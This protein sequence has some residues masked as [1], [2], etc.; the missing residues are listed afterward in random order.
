MTAIVVVAWAAL[1][2]GFTVVTLWRLA[3]RPRVP[4]PDA[5]PPLLL[6]RPADATSARERASLGAPLDYPGDVA[7]V[8]LAP[9]RPAALPPGV[10]WQASDPTTPNRKVGHVLH[11]LAAVPRAGRVVCVVDADVA[12]DGPL[13]RAL[14]SAVVRGAALATAA[15]APLP[16]PGLAAR[17]QRALLCHTHQS[18]DA[19]DAVA[20][21]AKPVCG[22]AMAL[23]DAALAILPSLR[24][25]VGEDLEL[26]KALH[27]AGEAVVLVEAS[28]RV[29]QE[30]DAPLAPVLERYTR[31]MQVLR[32]HRPWLFLSV[33]LLLAPSWPL[34]VLAPV[35]ASPAALA[36]VAML[37]VARCALAW[38]LA[39]T[40][41]GAWPLGEALLLAAFVRAAG[42]RVVVWRGRRFRL[43]RGGRML[44][45]VA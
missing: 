20:V 23:A 26:A 35:A 11:A 3:R 31:W 33:P 30:A 18:F 39:P 2:S 5:A 38:R 6:L 16:A 22:K 40:G 7:H 41:A 32:A 37:W 29:P 17:A 44:P 12:V 8:V 19:L 24:D 14:A 25:Q 45:L 21:G 1:A 15:P 9:E 42:R 34:A 13:L 10:V 28:A 36:A 4:R 27:A 43:A